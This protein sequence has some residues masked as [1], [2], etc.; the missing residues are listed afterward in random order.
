MRRAGLLL[1]SIV[2]GSCS[3]PIVPG[4][5]PSGAAIR[6][7]AQPDRGGGYRVVFTFYGTSSGEYPNAPLLAYKGKLYGTTKDGGTADKGTLYEVDSS[8]SESVLHSF[9]NGTDGAI[10]NTPLIVLFGVF[11]G[12]TTQGGKYGS[13]TV[14]DADMIG[15]ERVIHDF[16]NGTDGVHPLSAL[17]AFQGNLYGTTYAGGRYSQG[18]AYALALSG[19]ERVLHSFGKSFVNGKQPNSNLVPAGDKLYSTTYGGGL[20]RGGTVYSLTTNGAQH[21]IHAFGSGSDGANPYN[22]TLVELNG[23]FYGTTCYGGTHGYG[24]VF[25]ISTSGTESV[26]YN[27]GDTSHDGSCPTA[28]L[29]VEHGALYGTTY[30][31]GTDGDGT[32]FGVNPLGSEE[33]FHSFA[34]GYDGALPAATLVDLKGV[35]YGTTT[36]G[37]TDGFGTVFQIAPV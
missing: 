5:L 36:L 12:T 8:G 23:Y 7:A 18:T 28:G 27:F 3:H 21:V 4:A 17:S 11:Y 22:A 14:F 25:K 33:V 10:P 32:V 24:T 2:L 1:C 13:G 6:N 9:G 29:V 15:D 20:Y 30:G 37:G 19:K 34:G 31:G 16:G 26:V 35:L